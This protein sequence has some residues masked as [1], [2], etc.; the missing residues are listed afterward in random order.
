MLLFENDIQGKKWISFSNTSVGKCHELYW[1][2]RDLHCAWRD[3]L[4]AAASAAAADVF[5]RNPWLTLK[6]R[7]N[8]LETQPEIMTTLQPPLS[9]CEMAQRYLHEL[10][11]NLSHVRR[12]HGQRFTIADVCSIWPCSSSGFFLTIRIHHHGLF[13][14]TDDIR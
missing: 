6:N 8:V 12:C 7:G 13:L 4:N 1:R 5:A 14:I 2:Q 3:H 9:G 10:N 11:E